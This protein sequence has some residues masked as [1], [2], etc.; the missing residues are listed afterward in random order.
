MNSDDTGDDGA[1][2]AGTVDPAAGD[3]ATTDD[4]VAGDA[5]GGGD[6]GQLSPTAIGERLDAVEQG[7]EL[8]IN[9]RGTRFEVV[10]TDRY[11]VTVVDPRGNRYTLSQNLQTGGWRIHEEVRWVAP[12]EE[13]DDERG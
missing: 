4:P 2:D 10:G 12:V 6:D 11:A 9:D 1:G 7:D 3:E 5:T 13:A 8:L